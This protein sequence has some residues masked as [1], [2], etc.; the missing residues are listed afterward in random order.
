MN[1]KFRHASVGDIEVI[2]QFQVAMA[3]ETEG[4]ILDR[5]VCTQGVVEVF[6]HPH[7]G[8]YF[9]AE[10]QDELQLKGDTDFSSKVAACLLI[11][12]EWSDWRNGEVWWIHSVYVL[13]ELR[14]KKIFSKL[15][16]H[17]KSIVQDRQN[18]RGLRLYVD[19]RNIKAQKVYR[20]LEMT[21][22]H[23]DLFEWMKTF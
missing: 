6:S 3:F 17:V 2:V 10:M 11:V 7:R 16:Q 19:K 12:P 8:Q 1:I 13:P 18:V 5:E 9:V 20:N 21:D 4:I 15:Y 14:G 22:Q 23:Y